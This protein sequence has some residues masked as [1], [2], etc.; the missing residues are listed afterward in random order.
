LQHYVIAVR[1]SGPV[2]WWRTSIGRPLLKGFVIPITANRS[3]PQLPATVIILILVKYSLI[4][5]AASML[6]NEAQPES[7]NRCSRN[8]ETSFI[9]LQGSRYRQNDTGR[10]AGFRVARSVKRLGYGLK[11]WETYQNIWCHK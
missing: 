11:D 4:S 2:V 9:F 10:L 7:H 8:A 5:V 6:I 1:T 3:L